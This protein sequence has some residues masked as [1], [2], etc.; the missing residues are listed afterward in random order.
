MKKYTKDYKKSFKGIYFKQMR[1]IDLLNE[2]FQKFSAYFQHGKY[3]T[4]AFLIFYFLNKLKDFFWT[5][6][7]PYSVKKKDCFFVYGGRTCLFF[8]KVNKRKKFKPGHVLKLH[9]FYMHT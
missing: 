4:F 1:L 9:V 8:V 5:I 2:F 7:F 3:I 6:K